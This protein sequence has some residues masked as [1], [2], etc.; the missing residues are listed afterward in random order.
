MNA[1][2]A[3]VIEADETT[4]RTRSDP[5]AAAG[6][7]PLELSM[8]VLSVLRLLGR[9]WRATV[10]AVILTILGVV[11]AIVL[12]PPIYRSSGSIVLL[13]PP[14]APEVDPSATGSSVNAQNPYARFNDLSVVVDIIARIV[15]GEST[16]AVLKEEGVTGYEVAA[17]RNFSRGPLVEVTAEEATPEAA[18][19]A[20]RLVLEEVE[21]VLSVRQTAQGTDPTY[22]ITFD[23]VETPLKSTTLYASTARAAL[24]AL[25]VGGLYTLGLVVL[26]EAIAKKRAARRTRPPGDAMAPEMGDPGHQPGPNGSTRETHDPAVSSRPTV[27]RLSSRNESSRSARASTASRSGSDG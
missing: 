13:N 2:P 6:R 25:A 23:D 14:P 19:R 4:D 27:L 7:S 26:V 16:R 11:A 9:H 3:P 15:S 21:N 20:A 12:S 5:A 17:N 18:I 24:A 1:H 8:D 10:P 22:F